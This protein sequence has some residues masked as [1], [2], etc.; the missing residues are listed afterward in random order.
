MVTKNLKVA[1]INC[2]FDTFCPLRFNLAEHWDYK[3]NNICAHMENFRD[4]F[5]GNS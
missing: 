2:C 4:K 5:G 1:S 3:Y